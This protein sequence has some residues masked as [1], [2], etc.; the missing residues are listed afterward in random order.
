MFKAV[1][2]IFFLLGLVLLSSGCAYQQI[3]DAQGLTESTWCDARP[4]ADIG[5]ITI[6]EP[7]SSILVGFLAFFTLFAGFQFLRINSKAG[8]WWSLAL[9]LTG[10]G[11]FSAGISYQAFAYEVKCLGNPVCQWTSG[12]EIFYNWLTVL[13]AGALLLAVVHSTTLKKHKHFITAFA[14][15]VSVAYTGVL[16]IGMSLPSKFLLSFE[17]MLL[18][19]TPMM[20]GILIHHFGKRPHKHPELQKRYFVSW[21][22][23]FGTGFLYFLYL[24]SPIATSLWERGIWFN[25]NDLLHVTMILWIAYV[26]FKVRPSL[27]GVSPSDESQKKNFHE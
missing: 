3:P 12:F 10:L 9:L 4:C 27:R 26:H 8:K 11:A 2:R 16:V 24:V 6:S 14:G 22:L 20:L 13:G 5:S 18:F 19:S 25:A 21:V 1:I 15:I 7:S 17:C 23:L